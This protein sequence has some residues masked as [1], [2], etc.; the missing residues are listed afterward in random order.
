MTLEEA[1]KE[2]FNYYPQDLKLHSHKLVL[3]IYFQYGEFKI[4]S[5]HH[6]H[7]F[8]NS[9]SRVLNEAKK[10]KHLSEETKQLMSDAKKG[11]NHPMYGLHR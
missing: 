8:C 9:C 11:A 7:Y 1:R 5:K 10:G 2:A 4:T 3:A 6:Y